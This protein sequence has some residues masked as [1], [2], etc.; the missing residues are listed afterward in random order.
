[1]PVPKPFTRVPI[2]PV[3]KEKDRSKAGIRDE[4]HKGKLPI[5]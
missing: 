3:R 4:K 5:D 1:V 2:P